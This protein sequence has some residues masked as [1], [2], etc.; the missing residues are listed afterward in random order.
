MID[1]ENQPYLHTLPPV[2][3]LKV[4]PQSVSAGISI[5]QSL[6]SLIT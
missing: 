4:L 5:S 1:S 6:T 2:R 3:N